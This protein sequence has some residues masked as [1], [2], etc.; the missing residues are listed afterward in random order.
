M[1]ASARRG[2]RPRILG[3]VVALAGVLAGGSAAAQSEN[4]A[5][6]PVKGLTFGPLIPG[7][8]EAVSV[9][10]AAR[11][12]EVVLEGEGSADVLLVLPRALV[13]RTGGT[14]PLLFGPEDGA[15]VLT[16]SGGLSPV[17]PLRSTRVRLTGSVPVRL[18]L[19]G[20]AKPAREQPAGEYSTTIVVIVSHAGT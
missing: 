5:A 18:L 2:V 6:V 3:I 11:R 20:T 4:V 16:P 14:I 13:S 19:G 9:R 12:A 10:D 8:P 1:K 17:D 15:L 7:V